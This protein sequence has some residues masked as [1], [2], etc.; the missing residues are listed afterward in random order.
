VG[1]RE[2]AA[3][4]C[5][6]GAILGL[7]PGPWMLATQDREFVTQ[8]EDLEFLGLSRPTAEHDQL[9]DTAQRQIEERP[10]HRHPSRG[11]QGSEGAS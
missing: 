7:Q 2:L 4:R 11:R 8:H 1:S 9:K 6:Q 5:K 3:Q 10:D